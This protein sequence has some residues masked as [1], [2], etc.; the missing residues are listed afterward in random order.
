MSPHLHDNLSTLRLTWMRDNLDAELTDAL[1]HERCHATFIERLVEG[2]VA[3]KLSRSTERRLRAA[4]LPFRATLAG[5]DFTWPATINSALVRAL[6]TLDFMREKSNIVFIGTVG[7]GKTHLAAALCQRAC[8]QRK[9]ARFI[10][11]AEIINELEAARSGGYLGHALKRYRRVDLL[12]IDELGY[13]PVDKR[14]AELLFQVLSGRYERASTIIT[15]N[16]AYKDW[17][18]TFANDAAMTAA[19]LDRVIHHCHTIKITGK[20]RRQ[21]ETLDQDI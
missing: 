3:D 9:H 15:T 16:R 7:L 6:F 2:E 20:S 11:A 21:H 5:F 8:E 4:K 19:V 1:T 13:L 14:G 10:T 12:A 17:T 18:G